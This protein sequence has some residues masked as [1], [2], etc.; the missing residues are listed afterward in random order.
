MVSLWV[1]GAFTNNDKVE[2]DDQHESQANFPTDQHHHISNW[3]MPINLTVT[4]KDWS[5]DPAYE[6]FHE[7]LVTHILAHMRGSHYEGQETNFTDTQCH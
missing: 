6:A 1:V 3:G 2:E 7:K 4:L 5:Q